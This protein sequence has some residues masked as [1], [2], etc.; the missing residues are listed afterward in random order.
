MLGA[1]DLTEGDAVN[2][3]DVKEL[4]ASAVAN[5]A[6][7]RIDVDA[8]VRGGRRRHRLWVTATLGSVLVGLVIVAGVVV[9]ALPDGQ[10]V[11]VPDTTGNSRAPAGRP[12]TN[13]V[14][15]M[16]RWNALSIAGRDVTGY[17]D[18]NGLPAYVVFGVGKDA[19]SWQANGCSP[20]TWGTFT[21]SSDG[22]LAATIDGARGYVACPKLTAVPPNGVAAITNA[23]YL[24]LSTGGATRPAR[25]EMLDGRRQPL[26]LWQA[27]PTGTPGAMCAAALG[28][29]V[30]SAGP[31]TTV[32]HIR[33]LNL[34]PGGERVK[35]AFPGMSGEALA[36]YCWTGGKG[37]YAVTLD[38]RALRLATVVSGSSVPS[39]QPAAP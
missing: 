20:L 7:D 26:A 37:T 10:T 21:V 24:A 32:G 36:S 30:V 27:D 35:D 19:T 11:A 15:L 38:G 4:F 8:V 23:R 14:Q 5:P 29:D 39:G 18:D 16:G 28:R 34:G 22:G 1:D 12:V 17:R 13:P 2:E 9:K 3:T 6:A 25:L 31:L 33:S